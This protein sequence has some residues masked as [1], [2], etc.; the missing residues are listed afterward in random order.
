MLARDELLAKPAIGSVRSVPGFD[1]HA[2]LQACRELLLTCGGH[3]AAAGLRIEDGKIDAFREA[4]LAE[5][6]KRM[7]NELRQAQIQLDGETTLAGVTLQSIGELER[8]APF[9][10]G[11]KRPYLCASGVA[12][13]EPPRTM[14]NG[15]KHMSVKLVQNG[16]QIRAVA[17]GGAEWIPH[18]PPPGEPFNIAFKP[19][20]NEFRGRR[21]AEIELLDWRPNGIDVSVDLPTADATP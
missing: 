17:F 15:E 18:L 2:A 1:V 19:K 11:N 12:C 14:G 9:G 10:Q 4:F 3:A 8:L 5:V 21:T 20:I 16:V 13:A 7:P 6:T